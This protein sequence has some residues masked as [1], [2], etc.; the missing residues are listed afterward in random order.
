[1]G[2]DRANGYGENLGH[3]L[4]RHLREAMPPI[5][6]ERCTEALYILPGPLPVA[7][8]QQC[9]YLI[10]ADEVEEEQRCF[11]VVSY[12]YRLQRVGVRTLPIS[13]KSKVRA[14]PGGCKHLTRLYCESGGE[15]QRLHERLVCLLQAHHRLMHST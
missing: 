5:S 11:D 12:C 7:T 10:V 15:S 8:S 6:T 9:F 2:L 4:I 13:S 3:L 14:Q 1:M